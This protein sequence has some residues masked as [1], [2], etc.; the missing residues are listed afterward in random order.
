MQIKKIIIPTVT[1]AFLCALFAVLFFGFKFNDFTRPP[2]YLV[3]LGFTG[4]LTRALLS[5]KRMRDAIY[6][7]IIVF[8]LFTV[9]ILRTMRPITIPIF[10]IYL[11]VLLAAIFIYSNFFEPSLNR[12]QFARTLIL[13]ALVG[14]FYVAASFIHGLL[15]ISQ[16]K[17]H[18]LLGNLPVGFM[19]GL[20]IGLG[21]EISERYFAKLST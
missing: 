21:Q 5:E 10:L 14:L 4:A 15:F 1:A 3:T 13:A 11:A 16:M 20:G 6:L 18:S 9:V 8:I 12:V 17:I 7:N 2:I 19:L